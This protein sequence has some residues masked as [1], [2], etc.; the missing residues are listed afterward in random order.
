MTSSDTLLSAVMAL[1][2]E[3]VLL[4]DAETLRY[5]AFNDATCRMTGRSR[6]ELERLGPLGMWAETGGSA[7][8]LRNH[9]DELVAGSPAPLLHHAPIHRPDGSYIEV[10]MT[11]QALHVGGRWVI[12]V[13]G[14]PVTGRDLPPASIDIEALRRE[15]QDS[16]DAIALIDFRSMRYVDVNQATCDVLG[17]S[18]EELL[19]GD[20][21]LSGDRT[22]D[23]MQALYAGLV[24]RAP[25]AMV[26]KTFY[27]RSDGAQ[28]PGTVTRR[29]I[30][31]NGMWYIH[32]QVR[33]GETVPAREP[34]EP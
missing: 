23:D 4:I 21:P 12:L 17:Y 2:N 8:G 29:A 25:E 33:I 13:C 34:H 28:T 31:A 26:E 10:R 32:V 7:Q 27:H 5:I 20:L 3:A 19:E 11:R 24:I 18:R 15:M 1:V 16:A 22:L 9:Y 14:E 30:L 6:E